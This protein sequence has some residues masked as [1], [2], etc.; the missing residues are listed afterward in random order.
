MA[1]QIAIWQ[2]SLYCSSDS[3]D[4]FD[5]S[6]SSECYYSS[7]SSECYCSSDSSDFNAKLNNQRIVRLHFLVSYRLLLE[8]TRRLLVNRYNL[9][10]HSTEVHYLAVH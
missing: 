7:D 4:C 9:Q 10:I 2:A 3:S 6:D 8:V 5:S 1:S